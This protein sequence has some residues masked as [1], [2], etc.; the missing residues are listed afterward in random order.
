VTIGRGELPKFSD[1]WNGSSVAEL[2][3]ELIFRRGSEHIR[4]L[5]S[6]I[7]KRYHD[8]T[9]SV[10]LSSDSTL[11]ALGRSGRVTVSLHLGAKSS[12]KRVMKALSNARSLNELDRLLYNDRLWRVSIS[13]DALESRSV[14]S[15]GFCGFVS[16]DRIINST[17]RTLNPMTEAGLSGIVKVID[18][19]T[20]TASSRE[21]TPLVSTRNHLLSKRNNWLSLSRL[22]GEYWLHGDALDNT[23]SKWNY[24]RWYSH[25]SAGGNFILG[26]DLTHHSAQSSHHEWSTTM[27]GKKLFFCDKHFYVNDSDLLDDFNTA[28]R[29]CRQPIV[30]TYSAYF[31]S[32]LPDTEHTCPPPPGVVDL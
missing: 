13:P 7:E 5:R 21:L 2:D 22:E 18:A 23:C 9:S 6:H 19:L 25:I 4:A 14:P 32:T 17:D 16:M 12:A 3:D 1:K 24:S 29:Q 30:D 28:F 10:H 27:S 26:E 20:D 8:S 15:N 31:P 11:T